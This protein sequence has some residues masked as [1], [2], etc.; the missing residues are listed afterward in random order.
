M[1]ECEFQFLIEQE[2]RDVHLQV[3]PESARI[4]GY[5]YK[6]SRILVNLVDNAFKYSAPD[7]ELEVV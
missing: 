5:C 3:I 2:R 4:E 1:H 7:T 6:L